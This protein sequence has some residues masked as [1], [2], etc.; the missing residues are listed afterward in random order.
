MCSKSVFHYLQV[1]IY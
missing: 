1:I